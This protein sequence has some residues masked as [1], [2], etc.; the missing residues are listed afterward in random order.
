MSNKKI[1]YSFKGA[2]KDV[3]KSKHPRDYYVEAQ[4]IKILATDSQS[5]ASVTNEKGNELIVTIPAIALDNSTN[6]I[7][8]NTSTISYESN[9]EL[10]E[11]INNN[12]IGTSSSSQKIIGDVPTRNG[13]ILFSTDDLGFDCIWLVDKV[14]EGQ[15]ILKL[16]YVRNLG[17]STNN[18]IQALFNYE[19]DIIQKVYWVDGNNQLRFVNIEN[20][21]ENGDLENLIDLNSANIDITGNYNLSQ[22][23]IE[24]VTQGGTHTSGVIQYTYNL[25]KLNGSQTTIAPLSELRPLDLGTSL[26]GG[27]LNEIVGASPLVKIEDIDTRY[28][29]IKVYAIKY[30]SYNQLP[31]ISIIV[32]EEITN[33]NS[34]SYFDDGNVINN[35]SIS[36]FLFLG[37]NVFSPKHIES[38][39]NRLFA[40]NVK[41][42][43]FNFEI[44]ARAYSH[45]NIGVSVIYDDV[46]VNNNIPNGTSHTVNTTTYIVPE[47]HDSINLNYDLFKFQKDGSTI[48]G[49]GR[50]LKYEIVKKT[51]QQLEE[52]DLRLNQF[53]KDNEI[54]RIGI[55]FYNPLGQISQPFWIAD[56]KSPTGNLQGNYSTLKV[57]LN[58]PEINSYIDGL[59]LVINQ[60]PVGYK[61]IRADRTINDKTI[62]CQGNLSGMMVQ[63]TKDV[64]NFNYWKAPDPYSPNSESRRLE[65]LERPKLPILATRGFNF[66]GGPYPV[67]GYGHLK[68]LNEGVAEQDQEIYRED[69]TDYKRQQTW[70]Y[71][72]MMQLYSPDV[73]FD[74]GISF[75]NSMQLRVIGAYEDPIDGVWSK[76]RDTRSGN[77]TFNFVETGTNSFKRGSNFG[78]YGPG[79]DSED[80]ESIAARFL[81]LYRGYE[82]NLTPSSIG[83]YDIYGKPEI[84][85]RGQGNTSYNGDN[86]FRYINSLENLLSDRYK[87]TNRP[88]EDEDAIVSA[89]CFGAK[90]V[91]LVQG[92]DTQDEQDRLSLIDMFVNTNIANENCLLMAEIAFPDFYRYV[93]NIYGGN[94]YESKTRT[95]YIEIG[96]YNDITS[97]SVQI[98]SPGDTFVQD[99][100]FGRLLKTDTERFSSD[101][102]Q[103]SEILKYTVETSVNLINRS[104]LSIQEWDNKFQPRNDEYHEYNRV[105]SQQ[106]S[107]IQNQAESFKFKKVN[108]FDTRVISSKLKVPG[109]VIDNWTDFLENEVIDLDGKYGPINGLVS[110]K[111]SI[112]TFQDKAISLLSINPRVQVQGNDGVDIELGRGGILYDF[113]YL[114]TKSGSINKW[115]MVSTKKGIYYYDAL[116]K[117]VGRVPDATEMVLS[118]IKGFHSFFNTNY[119][120]NDI[121]VDNPL[122]QKGVVFGYDNYNNDVYFSILQ[123]ENSFT[124]C[125]N[126][127]KDEFIDLKTYQP[128]RYISIGERL[129]VTNPLDNKLYEQYKG[130]YNKFF[131]EYKPSY[132][133][134]Q[135]NPESNYDCVFDTIEY[136][137]ELYLNDID[138]PERTLSHI[139]AYNEYQ[140]SGRIPLVLGRNKNLR[141]K[142]REWKA[143]IPREGRNRIRN[144]WIY[145]KLELENTSNYK[146]ILHDIIINYTV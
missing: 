124:W 4:H 62:I 25:Y 108:S 33:F 44:D 31:Q 114:T 129:I 113:K 118:D 86:Q 6:T 77:E 53:F 36:E 92:T 143:L 121:V 116:N 107:L 120:Y 65:S 141:R 52:R 28:T 38:Q 45:N 14:L 17:F 46:T 134:L 61:I 105:Y 123:G 91:T 138:Q 81:Q 49:E 98:D 99:F 55:Q 27:E 130:E 73:L 11:Q 85:E 89:N 144:P 74:T 101:V 125:Y 76:V 135:V 140:D 40:S 3:T 145:L 34:F 19:N 115:G 16:L 90:C 8:Y 117:S 13:I 80:N 35:I 9:G 57:E 83:V 88:R 23:F 41:D 87:R 29:H 10:S 5:T 58:I 64:A 79:D 39:D 75:T 42:E 127:L 97:S 30:T 24:Q 137:S 18:P 82:N 12:L 119:N 43:N 68:M 103:M 133:I 106:P 128:S 112:F 32:D 47:K 54:Y 7:T 142:F 146:L 59:G 37:S 63:T 131:E 21:I 69:D 71:L 102:Q 22:P 26:G 20:S 109:E 136:T 70:Q 111:D 94:S 66:F 93:G 126:E 110:F 48:G 95:S 139:Q 100:Q 84:T 104:D 60:R 132:I 15:Y 1:R 78:M 96:K 2:L 67:L 51:F 122:K 72:K 50:F 56:F